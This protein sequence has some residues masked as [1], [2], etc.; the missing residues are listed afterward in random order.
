MELLK[1]CQDLYQELRDLEDLLTFVSKKLE[2]QDLSFEER[3]DLFKEE[4]RIAV[5]MSSIAEDLDKSL[6]KLSKEENMSF[7]AERMRQNAA[8]IV[9]EE[10]IE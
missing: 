10:V 4:F 3:E 2:K 1:K 5:D 7:L 8:Q 6:D 9:A